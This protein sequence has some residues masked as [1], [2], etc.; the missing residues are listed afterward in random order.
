[1]RPPCISFPTPTLPLAVW[2][3]VDNCQTFVEQKYKGFNCG[4]FTARNDIQDKLWVSKGQI[5]GLGNY[6]GQ[7]KYSFA[8]ISNPTPGTPRGGGVVFISQFPGETPEAEYI[9][10]HR[11]PPGQSLV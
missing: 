7:F 2:R 9:S 5:D 6:F 3:E 4:G 8:H 1:M 10:H 11:V